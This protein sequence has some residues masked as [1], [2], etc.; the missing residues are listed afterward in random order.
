MGCGGSKKKGQQTEKG[1][2]KEKEKEPAPQ[3]DIDDGKSKAAGG[4]GDGGHGAAAAGEQ[5]EEEEAATVPFGDE[6]GRCQAARSAA[7]HIRAA[8]RLLSSAATHCRPYP[9]GVLMV[10]AAVH[11]G[12]PG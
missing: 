10:R 6:V 11:A 3:S 1:K 7:P 8:V 5:A 4:G 12:V 9:P 2:E